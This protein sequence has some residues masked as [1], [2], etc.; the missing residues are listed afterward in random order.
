KL[1]LSEHTL[2]AQMMLAYWEKEEDY[3][4]Y[5][6]EGVI[7]YQQNGMSLIFKNEDTL[8]DRSQFVAIFCERQMKVKPYL[9]GAF[10]GYDR[11]RTPAIGEMF[12]ERVN[13]EEEQTQ[14]VEKNKVNSIIA[15]H[16]SARRWITLGKTLQ[17]L[18]DLSPAS[19]FA[20]IID[21]FIKSY[22]GIFAAVENGV[23]V[24]ELSIHDNLGN[25]SLSIVGHP[26]YKGTLK[27]QA[28][29]QLLI[30]RF[31]NTTTKA[32]LFLSLE[33]LPIREHYYQGDIMGIS[34]FDK[35][36]SG[37]IYLSSKFKEELPKYRGSE[38]SPAE[39]QQLPEPIL[40]ELMVLFKN[41]RLEKNLRDV[42]SQNPVQF[43]QH[44]VGG[45]TVEIEE[46]TGISKAQ[47]LIT[48][49]GKTMFTKGH[50][51]Y[52]GTAML[53]EGGVLSLYFTHANG[54][55]NCGQI[56]FRFGRKSRKDLGELKGSWHCMD[57]NFKARVLAVKLRLS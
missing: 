22:R 20:H 33:V 54:I 56:M 50:I 45:Y 16:L 47:L 29:G 38:L 11:N 1:T 23:F 34:R 13:S 48:E 28:S 31:I 36:F 5:F 6:Y 51:R 10:C 32:P 7:Q 39:I 40:S 15:Q 42:S 46:E 14:I 35:S 49:V 41:S 21:D 55:P 18:Q 9:V 43:I 25:A 3:S 26:M 19:K 27:V 12:F 53:C 57:E 17:N 4:E 30:G 24:L 44:L 52:E 37:K 2:K 8:L